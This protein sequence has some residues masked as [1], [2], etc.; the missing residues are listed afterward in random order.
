MAMTK[1]PTKR[2]VPFLPDLGDKGLL[3]NSFLEDRQ[4][5]KHIMCL[6]CWISCVY[7][8]YILMIIKIH[9]YIYIL[10]V[11]PSQ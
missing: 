6:V 4:L 7:I 1:S 2:E 8:N 5:N 3:A 10:G 11:A 9:I